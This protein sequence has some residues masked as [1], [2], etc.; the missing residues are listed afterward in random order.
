MNPCF[1]KRKLIAWL[2]LGDLEHHRAQD[3]RSHIQ[4]CEGCRQ[5]LA[6]ISALREGLAAVEKNPSPEL[7]ERFHREWV[8]R[9]KAEPSVSPW[10]L[11]TERLSWR[12][13]LPALGAAAAL[14]ILMLSLLPRQPVVSSP[15]RVS[16]RQ[17]TP[18]ARG[19]D[20]S[21]SV[22][23]YQRAALR[24]LDEFDDLLTAQA[25]RQPSPA[26]VYTASIFA[27]AASQN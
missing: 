23:N 27:A 22:A 25:D 5:Y 8:G 26:P 13:A 7:S 4:N 18:L 15:V 3:L 20:L 2:A 24:S 1:A 17:P 19:R 16:Q 12:V 14:L 11:L 9:L 10:Q 21:P 6:E